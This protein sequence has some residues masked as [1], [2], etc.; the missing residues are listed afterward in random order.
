[1]THLPRT[2]GRETYAARHI[3]RQARSIGGRRS[4]GIAWLSIEATASGLVV[5]VERLES[6]GAV[7]SASLASGG[8]C[9]GLV[10]S[11]E[12]CRKGEGPQLVA[13]AMDLERECD[14]ELG[15]QRSRSRSLAFEPE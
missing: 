12:G 2:A 5:I 13:E 4:L 9:T 15:G 14:I 1:M 11:G 3:K 7:S 8:M 6:G 10:N